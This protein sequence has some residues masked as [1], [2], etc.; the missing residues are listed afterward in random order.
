[1]ENVTFELKV[2][3]EFLI[4]ALGLLITIVGGIYAA[5]TSTKKYELTESF[6]REL[7]AWYSETVHIMIEFIHY[8]KSTSYSEEQ[9]Q[10]KHE[11]LSSLSAQTEIGRFY[12]PN[13]I[14]DDNFGDWKTEA[15]KGYRHINLEFL[16]HFYEIGLRSDCKNQIETLWEMERYFTSEIFKMI[17]PR[18]R[19]RMYSRYTELV[20]PKGKSMEDFLHE[21]LQ[22]RRIFWQ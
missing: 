20:M 4:S 7:L 9:I 10:K 18:K 1:M 3:L 15:Y 14:K 2:S 5:I 22:K 12:F 6:R 11:L 19:N 8:V 21:H 16:L 13:V 17:D